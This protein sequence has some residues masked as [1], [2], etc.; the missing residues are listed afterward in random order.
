MAVGKLTDEKKKI[1]ICIYFYDELPKTVANDT[2]KDNVM[3]TNYDSRQT[4][5]GE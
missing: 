3:L 2:C 5:N 1:R 4:I